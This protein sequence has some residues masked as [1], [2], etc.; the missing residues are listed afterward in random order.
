MR[1]CFE[2]TSNVFCT[3][4]KRHVN[5][6]MHMSECVYIYIYIYVDIHVYMRTS[7]KMNVWERSH[8][9]IAE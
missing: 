3:V 4:P 5:V 7:K 2:G 1:V 9:L 6:A 8:K